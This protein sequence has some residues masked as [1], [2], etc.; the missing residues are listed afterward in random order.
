MKCRH[1]QSELKLPL[2]D[3]GTAPPSNAF[4]HAE[5]L[6]QPEIYFPLRVLVCE[7]CWLVQTEDYAG[8]E[9]LFTDNYAYFSSYST[10]WLNH[11]KAYVDTAIKRF[12]LN[13][14]SCVVEIASNDGYLLQYVKAAGIPCFGIEPTKSTADAA[15]QKGI[16]TLDLFFGSAPAQALLASGQ[17]ADLMI[18]NN[19]LAHVPDINDFVSGFLFL[20]KPNGVVTFEFPHLLEMVTHNQFDTVY[21]EHYSYL[22]LTSVDTILASNGLTVFDVEHLPTH[23]GSL[24]VF[25]QRTDTGRHTVASTVRDLLNREQISGLKTKEFYATFQTKAETIKNELLTFL[26]E[27][28]SA[29]HSVGAYG[30]AAKGN[31]ILNYAGVRSDLIPYVVDRNPAKQGQY[32][33]GSHIP[34]FDEDHLRRHQPQFILILPWNLRDEIISQL[35]YVNE[36]GGRCVTAIPLLHVSESKEQ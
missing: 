26:I 11:A 23:G 27:A 18:A 31:T 9:A 12:S 19:V 14:Q 7:T 8:R 35:D 3:L 36:W 4:L 5:A 13:D 6:H 17:Q 20:L 25:A 22:S 1:C 33:P 10:S 29:G 16:Q 2:L 32:L 21:H 28:K 24:R 30:A 15:R 34:I